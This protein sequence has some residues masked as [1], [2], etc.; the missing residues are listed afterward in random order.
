MRSPYHRGNN[1]LGFTFVQ[2]QILASL[3]DRLAVNPKDVCAQFRHNSGAMTRVIDKLAER[4]WLERARRDRDR[5]KVELELT[6]AGREVIETR[7]PL[8]VEKQNLAL[9][10]FSG[11]EV[12]EFRRLLLKLTGVEST[13]NANNVNRRNRVPLGP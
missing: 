2:Y 7:A 13:K 1:A 4:G 10:Y 9:A 11:A 8:V 3:R 12:L 5:R 6:A